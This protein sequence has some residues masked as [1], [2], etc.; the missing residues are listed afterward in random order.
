[1]SKDFKDFLGSEGIIHKTSAPNTPQQNRLM[2]HM[3][4]TIWSG[5]CAILYHTGLKNSFWSEAL[6]VII[7]IIN[8]T[9][10]KRLDQ[11]TPHEVLTGQVPNMVYFHTF[12]CCTWVFNRKGK[13]LN[14]KNSPMIFIGY[15]PGS[16]AYRLWDPQGHKIVILADINFNK[17]TFPNKPEEK[18]VEPPTASDCQELGPKQIRRLKGLSRKPKALLTNDRTFAN[19]PELFF[20]KNEDKDTPLPPRAGLLNPQPQLPPPPPPAPI[21]P[22]VPVQPVPAQWIPPVVQ[23]QHQTTITPAGSPL[24][25]LARFSNLQVEWFHIPPLPHIQSG[26][27]QS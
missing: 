20:L 9:P 15:K 27:H 12:G 2:E 7:H 16:K 8:H 17:A 5:I 22:L 1:M 10:C 24:A 11:C 19:I 3:Q 23:I 25:C 14:A 4:Q 21:L 26:D 18:P 13:K 6:A